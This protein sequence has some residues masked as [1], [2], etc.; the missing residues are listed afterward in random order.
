MEININ[1]KKFIIVLALFSFLN[2]INADL[3]ESL[4]NNFVTPLT[5]TTKLKASKRDNVLELVNEFNISYNNIVILENKRLLKLPD[6]IAM[7]RKL[8]IKNDRVLSLGKK[9]YIQITEKDGSKKLFQGNFLIKFN[10]LPDFELFAFNNNIIFVSDLSDIQRGVFKT[11]NL[12]NL[13]EVLTNLLK[14]PN[15]INIELNTI[16]PDIRIR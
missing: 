15:I 4:K 6:N 1:N 14:D 5:A 8:N 9:E 12:F 10:N 13:E 11:D 2:E 7:D 3:N 16:D